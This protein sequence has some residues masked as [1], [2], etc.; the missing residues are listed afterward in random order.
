MSADATRLLTDLL[1][2]VSR[3]FYTTLHVLPGAVRRQISLAYLLA[4]AT[5]TIADTSLVPLEQRLAALQLFRERIQGLHQ[6][7]LA[8]EG[9]ARQ[10]GTP[11]ERRLL[12]RTQEALAVL[13][14]FES[15]DQQLIREVLQIITSGQELDLK[16]FTGASAEHI[17]ALQ[18]DSELDDYTYRV[19]G[20]VGE[21]WTRICRAHLFPAA[22]LDDERLL[23]DGVRFGKGLQLVNILRDLPADLRQGRCYVPADKLSGCRL[24]PCDLL[25][26]DAE[27]RLRPLY[28]AYLDKAAEHLKA[29]W[30]Y[31]ETLPRS[32]VRVRLACAW[33]ILIGVR[34]LARLR[35]ENVLDEE[36]RVK[37]SRAELRSILVRSI[38][39]YPFPGSWRRQFARAM[40]EVAPSR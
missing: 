36:R 10:Q 15:R 18:T 31:T 9:L 37:I 3:S 7:P 26:R 29:G 1:R 4:R 39:C 8:L 32:S 16:R 40:V 12:E 28:D 5:D 17:V 34:T 38:L 21:F 22:A 6:K 11:A 33:P 2:Q 13:S 14:G 30:R 24:R 20:C 35:V 27:S 23:A 25:Q 19:A